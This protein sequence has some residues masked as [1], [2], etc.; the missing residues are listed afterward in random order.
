MLRR[1]WDV[2]YF[3]WINLPEVVGHLDPILFGQFNQ[4]RVLDMPIHMPTQGWRI[5]GFLSQF[6]QT[7][8]LSQFY[9]TI[10]FAIR[11]E[12]RYG[13]FEKDHY[14]YI[15][16][17]QKMVYEGKTGRRPGAHS[18]AYIETRGEQIDLTLETADVIAEELGEVSHT[19][20]A[21]D[22]FPTEFFDVPFP[23]VDAS[24]V[25][26]L[27]TFDQ[28]ADSADPITYPGFTL[29]KLDP[30]VVHRCSTVTETTERTFV[31]VSFSRKRYARKGNT[32]NHLFTYDWE[33]TARSPH[34]RNHPWS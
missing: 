22:K 12:M 14:V 27:K 1:K 3:D 21:Y 20:I 10:L 18:D 8:L 11:S 32:I 31:K 15:T 25:G 5:P 9:Q 17:D 16:V 24:C 34:E 30:Y 4:I 2:R 6:Y 13:D 28:I 19:Y 29:L 33:M 7:I 26:S 23:I